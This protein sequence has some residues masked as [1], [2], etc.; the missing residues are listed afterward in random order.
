M[1]NFISRHI[2]QLVKREEPLYRWLMPMETVVLAYAVCTTL[3]LLLRWDSFAAPWQMLLM[4][5]QLAVATAL[6]W[7]LYRWHSCRLGII[8]RIVLQMVWLSKW[9][10][11]TY[12]FNLLLPN[13]DHVFAAAEQNIFGCQPALL[14]AEKISSPVFS[15]LMHLG[16]SSYFA[17]ILVVCLYYFFF[18]YQRLQTVAFT[19]TASFFAFYVIFILVPVAGPQY[20]YLAAG[21]DN[22][23]QGVF[24]N[25]GTWF[26]NHTEPLALPGWSDGIFYKTVIAAHTAGERP[27]AAF[28]SSH[29][30][31][32]VVLLWQ[33]WYSRSRWLFW[34]ILPFS[35][36]LFL[37]TVY[38]QAHYAIDALAGLFVGTLFFFTFAGIAK[39][40]ELR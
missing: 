28:P 21:V 5:A 14:F 35:L 15:E 26:H 16:Y 2:S 18:R 13:L 6:L 36:L 19:I 4:R 12:D 8:A 20:Y 3:L 11:E 30:G 23:V 40:M 31:I 25:V 24:P 17:L 29:V 39:K 32:T 7:A 22:I 27:T 37:S 10:P 33:A 9:Y 38:I 1:D 34:A